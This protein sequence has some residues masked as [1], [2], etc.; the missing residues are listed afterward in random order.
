[1]ETV[2]RGLLCF[3]VRSCLS[4][5]TECGVAIGECC[6]LLFSKDGLDSFIFVFTGLVF[7]VLFFGYVV[8]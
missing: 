4:R 7:S 1:M 8:F 5:E 6:L 2:S 3:L